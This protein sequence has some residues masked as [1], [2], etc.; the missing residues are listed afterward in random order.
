VRGLNRIPL[1]AA[2]IG[3]CRGWYPWRYPRQDFAQQEW[4]GSGVDHLKIK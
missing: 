1:V 2:V 3:W 4:L